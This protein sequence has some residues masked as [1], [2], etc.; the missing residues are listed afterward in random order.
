MHCKGYAVCQLD[1]L[2]STVVPIA[3]WDSGALGKLIGDELEVTLG[4]P[5]HYAIITFICDQNYN[6]GKPSFLHE[7]ADK[8]FR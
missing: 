3:K 1:T 5:V 6:Q 8:S 4:D 2:S 7:A